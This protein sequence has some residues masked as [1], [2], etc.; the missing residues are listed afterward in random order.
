M[1][2][3]VPSANAFPMWR[4]LASPVQDYLE[5]PRICCFVGRVP[6]A[7]ILQTLVVP[8]ANHS[9]ELVDARAPNVSERRELEFR[10]R[11]CLRLAERDRL[12]HCLPSIGGPPLQYAKA[13]GEMREGEYYF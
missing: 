8:A 12:P 2:A 5:T 13:V 3:S 7:P 10:V 9:V 6:L 11:R 1:R 4:T